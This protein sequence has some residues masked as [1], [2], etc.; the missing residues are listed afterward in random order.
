MK[1]EQND[2]NVNSSIYHFLVLKW[3]WE[4]L[5]TVFKLHLINC[6]HNIIATATIELLTTSEIATTL[7]LTMLHLCCLLLAAMCDSTY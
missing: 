7:L 4:L 1:I 6:N 5:H 2:E 3:E